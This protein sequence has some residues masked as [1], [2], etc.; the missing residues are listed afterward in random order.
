MADTKWNTTE[1]SIGVLFLDPSNPRI[2]PT[3]KSLSEPELI[4]E[5]VLHDDVL[6][7]AANI[8][9]NGFFPT[10]PL[11]AIRENGKLYVVEGNRRLAACKLLV[12]PDLAPESHKTRFKHLSTNIDTRQFNHIPVVIA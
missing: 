1:K 11:M 6:Q 12:N 5:L 4:E 3:P 10:E 8:Q 7:L 2:P 9:A